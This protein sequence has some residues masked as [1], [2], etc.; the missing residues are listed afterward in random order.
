MIKLDD[1]LKAITQLVKDVTPSKKAIVLYGIQWL[2]G[3]ALKA[4]SV[5]VD[6]T[7]ALKF[8]TTKLAGNDAVIAAYRKAVGK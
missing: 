2:A 6:P 7:A 1:A 3:Q 4:S 5:K 8:L